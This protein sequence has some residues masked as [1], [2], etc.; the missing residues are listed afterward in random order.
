MDR[1][2]FCCCFL[3]TII[4]SATSLHASF[5]YAFQPYYYQQHSSHI[6]Q[7]HKVGNYVQQE[8]YR[9]SWKPLHVQGRTADPS[10]IAYNRQYLID[11][12]GISEDKLDTRS[13]NVLTAEIGVLDERV[14]WLKDRL[15]LKENEIK[16]ICQQ[17]P[18]ILGLKSSSLVLPKLDYLTTKLLLDDKSLRKLYC[19]PQVFS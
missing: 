15:N 5:V 13:A 3:M 4:I 1:M 12:L 14:N 19:V 18:L 2:I 9:G 11:T 10:I 7:H 16:K 17:Q 8:Y 6:I